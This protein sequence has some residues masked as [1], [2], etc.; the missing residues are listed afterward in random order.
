MGRILALDYGRK[1]TGIAVTDE[2][3]IIATGLT[4]VR[5]LDL[6]DFLKDYTTKN[7]VDCFVV[8][9]PRQMNNLPSESAVYIDPFVKKLKSLYPAIRVERIDERFTSMMA[10]KAIRDAGAKKKDR[11]DKALI[12]TVSATLILQSYM[13]TKNCQ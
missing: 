4:T 10:V 1:R 2:M 9:E 3:Q 5:T 8:G 6:L 7:K 13:E 11:Q 12:D